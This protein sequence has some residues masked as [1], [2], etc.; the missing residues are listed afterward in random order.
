LLTAGLVVGCSGDDAPSADEL[1]GETETGDETGTPDLPEPTPDLPEP[2]PDLPRDDQPTCGDGVVDPGEDCDDGNELDADGC[3][4]DCRSSGVEL[5]SIRIEPEPPAPGARTRAA[6][7]GVTTF[8]DELIV[9]G[10]QE[11]AL[12]NMVDTQR[13]GW[14]AR[15]DG[16][17]TPHWETRVGQPT[18]TDELAAVEISG[19]S[20]F[21]SG[22]LDGHGRLLMIESYDGSLQQMLATLPGQRVH[23]HALLLGADA[24]MVGEQAGHAAARMYDQLF[25]P[26]LWEVELF[27][28]GF[29]AYYGVALAE[30]LEHAY[31]CGEL[32]SD[33]LGRQG[34][35]L[36]YDLA[37]GDSEWQQT[38]GDTSASAN[39]VAV[40]GD[41]VIVAGWRPVPE[42]GRNVYVA[43]FASNGALIWELDHDGGLG[44]DEG[45]LGVAVDSRGHVIVAGSTLPEHGQDP[46][47]L[48]LDGHGN[49]L[50]SRRLSEQPGSGTFMDVAVYHD[51][52]IALVG[53]DGP[54]AIV[55][56]LAP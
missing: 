48:K 9:V 42:D 11:F 29:A 54:A 23:D 5:F 33:G 30:D 17:G 43:R 16:E 14:I 51:D 56:V 34:W 12:A 18:T 15:Y 26:P 20:L 52:R 39:A 46:W 3:N 13:D 8:L 55:H 25:G 40:A 7:L 44:K 28:S 10:Y 21:V 6:A 45:A 24:V 4:V 22:T 36:R 19:P 27:G 2:T 49:E 1:A 53:A 35:L 32:A 50:W 47:V 41:H 38:F 31:V 37:T